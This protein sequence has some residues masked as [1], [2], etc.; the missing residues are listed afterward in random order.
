MAKLSQEEIT[1]ERLVQGMFDSK[2]KL[3]GLDEDMINRL[4]KE[5]FD[6]CEHK[7]YRSLSRWNITSFFILA[8]F[9]INGILISCLIVIINNNENQIARYLLPSLLFIGP[10]IYWFALRIYNRQKQVT[11]AIREYLENAL[12]PLLGLYSQ[13]F[14]KEWMNDKSKPENKYTTGEMLGI[15]LR[16]YLLITIMLIISFYFL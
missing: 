7:R 3:E 13:N 5:Y 2:S 12:G 4:E 9:G 8:S 14:I 1:P 6:L 11:Y 10:M 16:I 15:G